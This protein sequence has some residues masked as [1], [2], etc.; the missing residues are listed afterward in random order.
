MSQGL[1]QVQQHMLIL[2]MPGDLVGDVDSMI[3]EGT[4]AMG[5]AQENSLM[6]I[7]PDNETPAESMGPMDRFIVTLNGQKYSGLLMNLPAPVEAHKIIEGSNIIKSGDIAQV[8]QLFHTKAELEAA[9]GQLVKSTM[10][11]AVD[12]PRTD[13]VLNDGLSPATA[14]IVKG[15]FELTRKYVMPALNEVSDVVGEVSRAIKQRAVQV[16]DNPERLVLTTVDE[17]IVPFESW[18]VDEEN[19]M[20]ISVAFDR[21]ADAVDNINASPFLLEKILSLKSEGAEGTTGF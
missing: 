9:E 2:R 16:D 7:A 20:G 19:P 14:N 18:M 10:K 11:G 4:K 5:N 12:N 6:E 21:K 15:R 3:A 1:I 13:L 17:K 8:L